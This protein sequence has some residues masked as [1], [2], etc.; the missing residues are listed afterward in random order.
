MKRLATSYPLLL[1]AFPVLGTAA[2]NAGTYT[3]GDLLVV[4]AV[5]VAAFAVVLA[6]ATVFLRRLGAQVPALVTTLVVMLF[7]FYVPL[8]EG[9]DPWTRGTA[10]GHGGAVAMALVLT[11]VGIVVVMARRPKW[12]EAATRVLSV[13]A[14]LLVGWT[15]MRVAL[16]QLRGGGA[17]P[18]SALARELARPVPTRGQALRPLRDVYLIILDSYASRPILLEQFGFDDRPFEDS[19][20]A[21]GFTVPATTRSNYDMTEASLPSILNFAHMTPLAQ[22]VGSSVDRTLSRYLIRKNRLARFL[23]QQ[24]YRYVLIP[25]GWEVT[26]ESP[27]ADHVMRYVSGL[28]LVD[29]LD[30]TEFREAL[31]QSTLLDRLI[32]RLYRGPGR[33][34]LWL[35]S[36]FDSLVTVPADPAPT[37]TLAHF[38]MPHRPY[39]FDAACRPTPRS[40]WRAERYDAVHDSAYIGQVRCANRRVLAAVT[41]ILQRSDVPPVIV[42]QADHGSRKVGE[43]VQVTPE[44]FR[45]LARERFGA[46]GAYYLPGGGE[47]VLGDTVTAVN[48]FRHILSYYFD[49]ELPPEPN[50]AYF[51]GPGGNYLFVRADTAFVP[52]ATSVR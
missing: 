46:F 2:R 30:R 38:M 36:A 29:Q 33:S 23:K 8:R 19:L 7:F 49:A 20:R 51:M 10:F 3:L 35:L 45:S 32:S 27:D 44:G 14:L 52:A 47:R 6:L 37:F 43:D 41:A 48:V 39:R 11:A 40:F 50:S 12:L 16:Q 4:L 42:I 25:A 26:S 13:M 17:A 9:I 24:G 28:P 34:D 31:S 18:G 22:E 1:A 5:V 21:L 15:G